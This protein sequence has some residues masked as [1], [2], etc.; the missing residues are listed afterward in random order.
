MDAEQSFTAHCVTYRRNEA[1]ATTAS[2]SSARVAKY[3]DDGGLQG[4]TPPLSS[5]SSTDFVSI[6]L[7]LHFYLMFFLSITIILFFARMLNAEKLSCYGDGEGRLCLCWVKTV[8][9]EWRVVTTHQHRSP[10]PALSS[11]IPR[12][13]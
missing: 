2:C 7:Y 9:G 3:P 6:F 8:A 12:P 13:S 11:H 4:R 5:P 10:P 1:A